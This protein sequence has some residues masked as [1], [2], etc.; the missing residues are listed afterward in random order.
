MCTSPFEESGKPCVV[1]AV[2]SFEENGLNPAFF[3]TRRHKGLSSF[4]EN[5]VQTLPCVCILLLLLLHAYMIL[6]LIKSSFLSPENCLQ[7]NIYGNVA[8][9]F[10]FLFAVLF[11]PNIVFMHRYHTFTFFFVF[12]FLLFFFH[13]K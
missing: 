6:R 9:L 5:D 2:S 13:R 11:M 4:E 7:Y 10:H 3:R 1:S 8:F 12:V